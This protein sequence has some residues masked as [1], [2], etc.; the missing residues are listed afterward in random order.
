MIEVSYFL[1]KNNVKLKADV[2]RV[3]LTNNRADYFSVAL[4]DKSRYDGF[5]V[6]LKENLFKVIDEIS[7]NYKPIHIRHFGYKFEMVEEGYSAEYML[8]DNLNTLIVRFSKLSELNIMFDIKRIFD[9]SEWG[10]N[11]KLDNQGEVTI[12][13]F[14]KDGLKLYVAMNSLVNEEQR[15]LPQSYSYDKK[16]HSPPFQHWVYSP[17][18]VRTDT[19]I[20]SVSD[21]ICSAIEEYNYVKNNLTKLEAQQKERF[22][23]IPSCPSLSPEIALGFNLCCYHLANLSQ[24]NGLFAGL[25]WFPEVWSR[26]ELISLKA[27]IDL[28]KFQYAKKRLFHHIS[29]VHYQGMLPSKQDSQLKAADAFGWLFKRLLELH[30][31]TKDKGLL[32]ESEKRFVLERAILTYEAVHR[33]H[34]RSGLVYN[35]AKETWMDSIPREGFRLEIQALLITLLELLRLLSKDTDYYHAERRFV[36][37]VKQN[38]FKDGYLWDSP[39]DHTFRPNIFIAAYVAPN[40]LTH[41][42]WE[43][44]FDKAIDRLWFDWGG[45]STVDKHSLEFI[46][47]HTGEQPDSYHNGDSWFFLN[48]LAAIVMHRIDRHKYKLYVDKIIQAS[49]CDILKGNAIGCHSELS[50]A[51]ELDSNGA[52]LQAWSCA[53]YIELIN[54]VLKLEEKQ[55]WLN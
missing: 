44:C 6:R 1:P 27:L 51:A 8:F 35:S 41:S 34:T 37:R 18:L 23:S 17:G 4:G 21:N 26:D 30:F 52:W 3:M 36:T 13:Q 15:W 49:T 19:L 40:L 7:F 48:N 39:N 28:G 16:R 47:F 31:I 11:Y 53:T 12:I 54:E 9:N 32:S 29:E 50:S 14:E 46:K 20:I 22:N 38:F 25:P 55:R 42:E 10:R 33:Y 2:K 24:T 45:F 43:S 5:Y